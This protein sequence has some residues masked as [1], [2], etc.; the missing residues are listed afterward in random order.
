M[1]TAIV[2]LNWNGKSFLEKFLQTLIEN[3]NLPSVEIVVADN[4]STDGSQE[5]MKQNHPSIRLIE[6]AE[7]SGYTGGYNKSLAL[8][9]A[10]YFLLLN[11]DIE[12]PPN[13]LPPL[14]EAMDSDPKV[15][16]CM[17]KIL[18]FTNRDH[19]EYAGACGGFID[20]FGYPFC[21]GRILSCIERDIGQYDQPC[22]IFWA[23]GAAFMIR[24]SL[25][26]QFGGFDD[27][28]FAHME[29]IDLCWRTKRAGHKIM[30]IPQST[31]FHVGG[32]TLPNDSPHKLYLNY[33]NNLLML[34]KN[35]PKK[36]RRAVLLCRLFLDIA[37]ALIYLLQGKPTLHKSIWQAHRDFFKIKKQIMR[38]KDIS[39]AVYRNMSGR[40]KGSIVLSFFTSGKK[41]K[42]SDLHL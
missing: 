35:L 7:N 42:F 16:I 41:K 2:I 36:T 24:S 1:T 28:F 37:S 12:V 22:E 34:H 27:T 18:S 13:W 5:W 33:R 8:I 10:D 14:I 30:V 40:H 38:E 23:S 32:G 26:R 3:S 39:P 11:S 19:F 21:R 15:G 29:E 31:V 20:R 9:E 17:P 25:F 4:G 6:M